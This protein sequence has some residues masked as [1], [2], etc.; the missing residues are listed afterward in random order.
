MDLHHV[1]LNLLVALEVLLD[2]CHVSN[3]ADRLNISQPAMSRTLSR[4]RTTFGDPLL[5]RV[6]NGYERTERG[7]AI[8]EKL[9][10][11]LNQI[12]LTFMKPEFDPT[13][14]TGV[15]RIATLDY[16]ELVVLPAFMRSVTACAPNMQIELVRK[17]FNSVEEILVGSADLSIGIMPN[18]TPKHCMVQKLFEDDYVCAMHKDH[19]LANSELTMDGYLKH[20]HATIHTGPSHGSIID[21]TLERMGHTRFIAKRSPHFITSLLT[22]GE[23]NLMQSTAKRS[24]LRLQEASDLVVKELP[25]PMKPLTI[26]QAWHERHN[27]NPSHKWF[28]DQVALAAADSDIGAHS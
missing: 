6:T 15:F 19:P 17:G 12:R 25:F 22:L 21:D 14:A 1:D 18:T 27:H 7:D 2:E 9:A 8:A 13:T 20:P 11:T 24:A 10:E 28:R 5:V 3:S 4:L 16:G 23:S 26:S